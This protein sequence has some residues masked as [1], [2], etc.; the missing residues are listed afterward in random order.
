MTDP[1][2]NASPQSV[3][4]AI[5]GTD[6]NG[7]ALPWAQVAMFFDGHMFGRSKDYAFP[8]GSN[9]SASRLDQ[10]TS[11]A[12]LTTRTQT[13]ADKN[14]YD[15]WDCVFTIAKWVVKNDPTI[16]DDEVLSVNHKAS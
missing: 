4:D 7:N 10:I 16:N 1:N 14:D 12:K 5:A 15:L 11:M 13:L 2:A 6:G 8:E 9:T 3:S